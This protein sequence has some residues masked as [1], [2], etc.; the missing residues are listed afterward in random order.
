MRKTFLLLILFFS[1][2]YSFS[3]KNGSIKGVAYDTLGKHPVPNATVTLL[4]NKDSSLVSFTMADRNGR[5]GFTNLAAGNYRL[6]ITHIIYHN[7]VTNFSIDDN[8]K[9]LDFG[10]I[11]MNDKS[12]VLNEVVVN[13]EAPPVTLLGDTIQYNAGSFKTQPNASVEDLLKRLPGVSVDKD[14]T[15]KA[16]GETVKKVLVDGKEFFGDDPKMATKNLPADAIDKV[17]VYNKLSDQAELTGFDDGNSEKTINLK[18]KKD[19]KKGVFGK[20]NGGGGTDGRYAGKFNVNSFKG[21]R[22]MSVIGMT[23]NTNAAGFSFMDALSFTGA[24]NQLKGGGG[25]ININISKDND[26]GGL[27]GGNANS[28]I[29]TILGT[30]VNYNNIIGKK[31]DFQSNYF[32]SRYNPTSISETQRQYFL[33]ANLYKQNAYNNNLNFNHRLNMRADIQLDS[34]HS[35]KI[36]PSLNYQETRNHSSSGYTT[37]SPGNNY[38]NN[39]SSD[40]TTGNNGYNFNTSILYRQRFHKRGR[41]FSL[42]LLTNLNDN[43]GDGKLQSLTKFYDSVGTLSQIDS[44]NQKN[45]NEATLTGFNARAVYTEPVFHKSLLEFSAGRSATKSTASKTTYDFNNANGKY[46]IPDNLLTNDFENTYAFTNG[47]I[48]FLKKQSKY[49]IAAGFMWQ[50]AALQGKIISGAKDSTL[51]KTFKNILPAARFQY[52][53]SQFKYI[54]LSYQTNTNQPAVSQLQPVPDNSNPLYVKEGNPSLKQEYTHNIL[55]NASIVNPFKNLNLFAF[56]NFQKTENKIVN[57]DRINSLGVDSVMPVNVNG[58]YN[59]SGNLSFGFPVHFLKGSMNIGSDVNLYDGKQFINDRSNAIKTN[60]FSPTLRLDMNPSDK[61]NVAFSSTISF[62]NSKY[63]IE[64]SLN[65]RYINQ[66]YSASTDIQLPKRFFF[67]TDFD[68]LINGQPVQGFNAKVPL[69]NAS[70]SRQ[71]LHFNRGEIKFSVKDILDQNIGISRTTNQN[72]IEDTRINNLRRF[73]MLSFTL[74]LSKVGLQGEGGGGNV[75]FIS[76]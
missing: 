36:S 3:Q 47:G 45:N 23:N 14:G 9:A 75:R 16:Q 40:N 31:T 10:N 25:N 43:T 38:V 18:L 15:V 54:A 5:F 58:V 56:F 53:L 62:N 42:N 61:I 70:I 22:Q 59:L 48:R 44:I 73:F 19:K 30:G 26:L 13:A 2:L 34:F 27:V 74:S 50:Q 63:S 11:V 51:T 28:G 32:F 29:N 41:T 35:I 71:I 46:D 21:A 4:R 1:F 8:H 66:E 49:S 68:Y 12:V 6:L 55:L 20:I 24:L 17:Q 76:K 64:S 57:N 39:G 52:N 65:N 67:S 72:Y 33:P 37:L 7:S 60:T 69:W